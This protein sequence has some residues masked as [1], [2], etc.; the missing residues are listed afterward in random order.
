MKICI[1]TKFTPGT[2]IELTIPTGITPHT[3]I[4]DGINDFIS[5][6]ELI[7]SQ[8][9]SL[10]LTWDNDNLYIGFY[11]LDLA[12]ADLF[13]S[14][15]TDQTPGS[16]ATSGSWGR[17]DF[18]DPYLPEFMVAIEGGGG[19]MQVNNFD[20]VNW[21]YPGNG[22]IGSSYEG[23]SGNGQ[24]E[25]SIPWSNLGN[26]EGFAL[27]VHVS[28]E[29]TQI[30]PVIFPS[31]NSTGDHPTITHFYAFF[32]PYF[33]SPQPVSGVGPNDVFTVPNSSPQIISSIPDEGLLEMVVGETENFSITASDAE[34]DQI[35]YTWKL[36]GL[37][38]GMSNSFAFNA[39]A[40]NIGS[41]SLIAIITDQVPGNNADTLFWNIDVNESALTIHTRV[42]LEGPFNGLT[43][44]TELNTLEVL[45][46]S[47]P[48][49]GVPWNYS[50][51]EEVIS[52][53][54][55]NIV[56]WL[57]IE[58]RDAPNSGSANPAT[59]VA[60]KACFVR[61]NGI[62]TGIDGNA[63]LTFNISIIDSL[64]LVIHHRDHLGIMSAFGLAESGG[65]YSWDFT[66]SENQVFGGSL[67]YR[68][69]SPGVW[70]MVGGDA[71]ADGEID[72]NDK[73]LG[74][75]SV[76]GG[77]G[78]VQEDFSLDALVNNIDKNDI[79]FP[80]SGLGS[81]VLES[82]SKNF[83]SQIPK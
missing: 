19:S 37:S 27:A 52:I 1:T 57:L 7:E 31:L 81:Q 33:T 16:G 6:T 22:V 29:D 11:S 15:D 35:F 55:I 2:S 17:V 75:G 8:T 71:N 23:W 83:T 78:Y 4:V 10:Y 72:E 46:L 21:N 32:S 66:L 49:S 65:I 28:E 20:G 74:W 80:N 12:T 59:I 40:G 14:I 51:T 62:I 53:P 36:D 63:D 47:Q 76:A 77:S 82:G 45:P 54:G 3:I 30:V 9:Y 43:M 60:Q 13:V 44:N 64:Y 56:D 42:F 26:P 18:V 24:T 58:L 38:V 25:I 79:W 39:T 73:T 50:G 5:E 70:G 41:H 67:G 69:L 61:N 48:Y 34:N 68:E